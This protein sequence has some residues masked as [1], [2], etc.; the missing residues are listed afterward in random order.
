VYILIWMAVPCR[1]LLF[2]ELELR[3]LLLLLLLYGCM[4]VFFLP[5]AVFFVFCCLWP[6]YDRPIPF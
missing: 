5:C 2:A 1:C 6:S 3:A 4:A